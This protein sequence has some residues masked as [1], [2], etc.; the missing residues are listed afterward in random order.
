MSSVSSHSLGLT[1]APALAVARAR[2][3]PSSWGLPTLFGVLLLCTIALRVPA[4][5]V[6]VFNSDETFLATQ[7]HV[8]DH[9]G[10]LYIDA[11][12]RKPPLVPYLY[13]AALLVTGSTAL[14][15]PRVLAMLAVALTAVLLAAEA[16]RRYGRHAAWP[17]GLLFVLASISFAAQ[18]GQAANF[19]LFMLPAM[20]AAVLL[21][22]RGR[23][24]AS[25][26]SL[27]VATLA[28]QTGA[29]AF[30]PV[31]YLL[32]RARG[33]RT[34]RDAG[35]GFAAPIIVV[36]LLVGPTQLFFW[37]VLGNGSYLGVR[38]ALAFVALRFVLQT[39]IFVV[40]QLP[41][42]VLLLLAWRYRRADLDLWLWLASSCI[43]V[44]VG[45]RFF[46]H[47]YLQLLPPLCLLAAGALVQVDRFVRRAI[48][49]VAIVV[50]VGF[51][52]SAFFTTSE[53]PYAAVSRFIA[54]HSQ[55]DDRI[56]VWGHVPEIYW[57]SQR[58]PATRF[59]TTGFLT[60]HWGGR[61]AQQAS[62]E[63]ATPGAWVMFLE[64]MDHHPPLY[65]IDT[66]AA[67]IRD[68][69]YYPMS[70]YPKVADLVRE[71]YAYVRSVDGIAVYERRPDAP[72]GLAA[73]R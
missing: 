26:A 33:R 21:A 57:A 22:A 1:R 3:G 23:G 56:L 73:R 32:A 52:M 18:D 63:L 43:S 45:F 11:A 12:D 59:P 2:R 19:E 72:K 16:R 5:T 27:A 17:A 44:A 8:L 36:A 70:K 9:G 58:E 34:V 6:P 64:D 29:A 55:R 31:V 48:V 49:A 62:P 10:R 46:G 42:V 71:Q 54:R 65:V 67:N 38:D 30:L 13:A 24:Y 61:P 41:I 7:A 35:L 4:F 68:S 40:S 14:V 50:G 39:F 51:S 69:K 60:G 66:S 20:T 47:Y 25:G 53:P 37:A 28:K 15:W